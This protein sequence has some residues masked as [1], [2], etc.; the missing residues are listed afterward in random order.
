MT[1]R[2]QVFILTYCR[3]KEYFYGTELVFKT[4]RVGFPNATVTVV[5]NASISELQGEIA[6]LARKNDCEFRQLPGRGLTH[7]EFLETTIRDAATRGRDRGPIVFL[8]PDICL[9]DSCEDFEFD[10]L[11]AGKMISAHYDARTSTVT[12]PR[13]H[14]SFLWITNAAGLWE[15]I[16]KIRLRH[17]DFHPFLSASFAMDGKWYRYDTGAGLVNALFQAVTAFG[18]EHLKR[19]DHL[20]GGSHLDWLVP[21]LPE[22]HKAMLV[23][24][25]Q[26]AREGNLEA[27]H[28]IR[29]WQ[30][31][32]W[33]ECRGVAAGYTP[34]PCCARQ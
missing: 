32:V 17:F 9:W 3:K 22:E 25:H 20:F 19:Y 28:G 7:H 1:E 21:V 14:T 18:E 29:H 4:L 33:K 11:L 8:D 2:P 13:L 6:S 31:A 12:M 16:R 10:G 24:L 5:D 30:D 15:A 27:L 23:Q 26:W 34:R